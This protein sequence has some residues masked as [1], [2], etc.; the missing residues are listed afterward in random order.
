MRKK[1]ALLI[2]CFNWY[3]QRLSVI[4]QLLLND[5]YNV[6]VLIADFEHISK[7]NIKEKYPECTYVKVPRYTRNLSVSRVKSHLAFGK[8]VEQFLD[9][10]VPDL[11]FL[12]IPPNN[13]AKYCLEYKIKHPQVRYFIDLID[14]WPESLPLGGLK[15]T[16][17]ARYWKKMRDDSLKIADHVFTECELYQ[18]KLRDILDEEKTSTLYLFKDQT[19]EEK[20][21]ICKIIAEK[22]RNNSENSLDFAYLGSINNILDMEGI[23]KI[24]M[25][26]VSY[27]F[28]TAIHIIGEGEGK[29]KFFRLLREAKIQVYYYG[30]MY[31]QIEIIHILAN[32]DFGL[33]MMKKEVSVGLTIKSIDYFSMGLPIINNINGDTWLFIEKHKIGINVKNDICITDIVD[34]KNS[35]NSERKRVYNFYNKYFTKHHF[36]NEIIQQLKNKD[37]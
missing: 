29:N 2:S 1:N 16:L 10:I 6:I 30:A 37:Q 26:S 24:L 36:E 13:S 22:E 12:Q 21:L 31:D 8:A 11:V 27:G 7:Q 28:K 15:K 32:C 4:R 23:C 14:L 18:E 17:F 20:E 9:K 35:K 33:N 34:F 25:L 5:E 3:K 19:D